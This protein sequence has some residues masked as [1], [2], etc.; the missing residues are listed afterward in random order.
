MIIEGTVNGE[1]FEQY[2]RSCLIPILQPFNWVNSHSVVI[3]DNVSI[4]HV[5]GVT[6]LIENQ[7]GA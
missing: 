3:L 5:D 2:I 7:V 1:K 4:H 6:D